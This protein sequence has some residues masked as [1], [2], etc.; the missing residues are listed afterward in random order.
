MAIS[1]QRCCSVVHAGID[2]TQ[3]CES[4]RSSPARR[5]C[6][7]SDPGIPRNGGPG[8]FPSRWLR[9]NFLEKEQKATEKQPIPRWPMSDFFP[10]LL[11]IWPVY[12]TYNDQT[13]LGLGTL[14]Q[15]PVNV[16]LWGS[17]Q[18]FCRK[19]VFVQYLINPC[20]CVQGSPKNAQQFFS[21]TWIILSPY[22]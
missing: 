16:C 6:Q 12:I 10:Q 22:Y 14:P 21:R 9:G 5:R 4:W 8:R 11:K 17:I 13:V 2:S 15:K 19:H 1:K 7:S 3:P 20:S 18:E